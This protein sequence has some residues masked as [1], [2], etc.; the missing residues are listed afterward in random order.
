MTKYMIAFRALLL[1]AI[2]SAAAT[3]EDVAEDSLQQ[4]WNPAPP[5]A[6]AANPANAAAAAKPA[7][8]AAIAV[9]PAIDVSI[10]S[11]VDKLNAE[12]LQI[13]NTMKKYR[14]SIDVANKKF[15][16]T[17]ITATEAKTTAINLAKTNSIKI[18]ESVNT[19]TK[20]RI[21][22]IVTHVK[23]LRETAVNTGENIATALETIKTKLGGQAE[24]SLIEEQSSAEE[25]SITV[26]VKNLK[27]GQE[28][29]SKEMGFYKV[30]ISK[31]QAQFTNTIE[32]A[33]RQQQKEIDF[34]TTTA[35]TAM[36]KIQQTHTSALQG[37]LNNVKAIKT[38]SEGAQKV[39]DT[40][41]IAIHQAVGNGKLGAVSTM[42]M[43]KNLIVPLEDADMIVNEPE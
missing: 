28:D 30:T 10:S 15:N 7:T 6:P 9:K 39:M 16:T 43:D 21:A 11:W 32:K 8:S 35:D 25:N 40:A 4:A 1:V 5:P 31:A 19:L 29:I 20:A 22:K 12:Q 23:A 14:S 42:L 36:K 13:E 24:F 17:L 38:A 34:A 27:A 2:F 33:N 18:F 3:S 41:K 26:Q 37:I